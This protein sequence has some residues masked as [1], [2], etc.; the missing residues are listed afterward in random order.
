MI[1]P[2]NTLIVILVIQEFRF[3]YSNKASELTFSISP[4]YVLDRATP[5][6]L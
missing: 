3:S 1:P 6:F 2:K 5:L 4:E